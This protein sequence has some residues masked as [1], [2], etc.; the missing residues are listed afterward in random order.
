VCGFHLLSY[1]EAPLSKDIVNSNLFKTKIP[2]ICFFLNIQYVVKLCSIFIKF[3]L[4]ITFHKRRAT[5]KIIWMLLRKMILT[6]YVKINV[7]R[8]GH[9]LFKLVFLYYNFS[10][11]IL[12]YIYKNNIYI[13]ICLTEKI[14]DKSYLV[15]SHTMNVVTWSIAFYQETR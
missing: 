6:T 14:P 2:S 4:L 13:K 11:K 1:E 15:V 12:F 7:I 10:F 9:L 3:C 8:G 5:A